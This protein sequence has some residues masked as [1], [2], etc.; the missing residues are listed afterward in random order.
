MREHTVRPDDSPARIAIEYAGCPKCARDLVAANPHKEAVIYPNGFVTFKNLRAGERLALPDKWFSKELDDRPKKYFAALPH[1]DGRTLSSLGLAAASS[2]LGNY[3]ALDAA[4]A[5]IGALSAMNDREFNAAVAGAIANLESAV[6]EVSIDPAASV[7]ADKARSAID[8]AATL[9]TSLGAAI[10]SGDQ[11]AGAQARRSILEALSGA[12]VNARTA[13]NTYYGDHPT[14]AVPQASTA[15]ND[16]IASIAKAVAAAVAADPNYC[17]SVSQ[18]G[19]AMNTAIHAFKSAWNAANPGAPVPINTGTYEQATADALAKV[20][21]SA[22]PAC[23]AR[24]GDTSPSF[25]GGDVV[26]PQP[27]EGLSLG[28]I[29]GLSLLGAGAVGGAIYFATKDPPRRRVRRS[30]PRREKNPMI[31]REEDTI[32]PWRKS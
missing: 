9:T 26:P 25:P 11:A 32:A 30:R 21:G 22:P 29:L 27:S 28:S 8:Q 12:L 18:V 15:P 6:Q 1:P 10:A 14:S 3:S 13:L 24:G 4:S 31:R 16:T 17:T 20:L 23:G 7:Y 19:S 5:A 2:V